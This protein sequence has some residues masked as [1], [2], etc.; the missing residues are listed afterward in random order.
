M[1]RDRDQPSPRETDKT[2]AGAKPSALTP[3]TPQ[4]KSPKRLSPRNKPVNRTDPLRK[5]E[6]SSYF[7]LS[8]Q[9][10]KNGLLY[11]YLSPTIRK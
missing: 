6:R 8:Y 11:T 5:R 7:W 9:I 2:K 10:D 1:H 4:E 3:Y